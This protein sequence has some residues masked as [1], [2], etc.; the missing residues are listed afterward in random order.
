MSY[1]G[2]QKSRR[3]AFNTSVMAELDLP[4]NEAVLVDDTLYILGNGGLDLATMK[5]PE[6]PK[7]EARLLMENF[8]NVLAPAGMRFEM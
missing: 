2:E 1:A 4:F 3:Q 7:E 8:K 5:P 6:D